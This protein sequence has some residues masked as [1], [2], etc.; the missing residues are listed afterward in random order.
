MI[1]RIKV[2]RRC[3]ILTVKVSIPT[4]KAEVLANETET[5][6]KYMEENQLSV[7]HR[8]STQLGLCSESTTAHRGCSVSSRIYESNS[9][10]GQ[11]GGTE[12]FQEKGIKSFT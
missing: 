4:T 12:P 10:S 2:A 5:R 9:T 6:T 7:V 3:P 11:M 8:M 1:L